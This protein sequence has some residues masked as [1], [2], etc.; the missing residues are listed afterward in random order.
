MYFYNGTKS[1]NFFREWQNVAPVLI[2]PSLQNKQNIK[3]PKSYTMKN[4]AAIAFI[5]A[6]F[7]ATSSSATTISDVQPGLT[8][9]SEEG[10]GSI[11]TPTSLCF[12]SC[13]AR[14]LSTRGFLNCLDGC[15]SACRSGCG[16]VYSTCVRNCFENPLLSETAST[17]RRDCY[18]RRNDVCYSRCDT[19]RANAF[20]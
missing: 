12:D 4:F 14:T 3:D 19:E 20:R 16:D 7:A 10:F 2:K 9:L 8:E 5:F 1:A 11:E 17:C 15:L 6:A 18:N 13:L